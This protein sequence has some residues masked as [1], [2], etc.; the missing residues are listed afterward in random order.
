MGRSRK[1]DGLVASSGCL[2]ETVRRLEGQVD[3]SYGSALFAALVTFATACSSPPANEFREDAESSPE[4]GSGS[5][6]GSASSSESGSPFDAEAG[7]AGDGPEPDAPTTCR[8]KFASGLNAAWINFASDVPN[9]DLGKFDTLFANTFA[10]GGR[11]VRWWFHTNGTVTPRYDSSGIAQAL[12]A[13]EI[14]DVKH[15]LDHANA[16]GVGVDISL[17]SFDMLQGDNEL[18]PA[19]I[20]ANNRNL[21]R[22]D[23]NRQAYVDNVLTPLVTALRGHPGLYCWEIFNE[24]EGMTTQNGWVPDANKVDENVVQETVNWFAAAIHAADP[25]ALVTNGAWSF[26]ANSTVGG[27]Q[28]LYSDQALVAVGGKGTGTL[29]FYEVHYYDNWGPEGSANGASAIASPFTHPAAYWALGDNKPIVIGEFYPIDTNGVAAADLYTNL[30]DGGYGGAWARQY[31]NADPAPTIDL[32]G[33]VV[34]IDAATSWPAMQVPMQNL[35]EAH[36]A[37]LTCP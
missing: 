8:P 29:D 32:D 6:S 4:S 17:W 16:A 27:N 31:E 12:T 33:Q 19:T 14:D 23:A 5:E 24:P 26:L 36:M 9:P 28:N 2:C 35:Y 11:V 1:V 30:Y 7:A 21:L 34:P 3:H 20:T 15:I 37:E 18:I 25:S 10:A 13:S 22:M